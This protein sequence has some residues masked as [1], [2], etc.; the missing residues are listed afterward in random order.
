[1][2]RHICLLCWYERGLFPSADVDIVVDVD[3]NVFAV[4]AITE[5]D[6]NNLQQSCNKTKSSMRISFL[7]ISV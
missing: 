5:K 7:S 3:V 1:M 6:T 4:L 2:P